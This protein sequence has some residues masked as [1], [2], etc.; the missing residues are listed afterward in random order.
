MEFL[1]HSGQKYVYYET[2]ELIGSPFEE[3]RATQ[4]NMPRG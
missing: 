1:P 4:T 2:D 3:K